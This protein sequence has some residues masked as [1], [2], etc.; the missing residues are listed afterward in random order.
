VGAAAGVL[1]IR[2]GVLDLAVGKYVYDKLRHAGELHIV[3]DLF[4]E[5]KRHG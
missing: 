3:S 4:H 1:A 2:S 5:L